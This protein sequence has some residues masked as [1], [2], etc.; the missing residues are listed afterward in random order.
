M[1]I[2][3]AAIKGVPEELIEAARID[4]ASEIQVFRRIIVP[5]I[6]GSLITVA[7]TIF[8]VILKVFDIVF[9]TTGGRFGSDVIANRM[10]QELVRFRNPGLAS[11]LA[12][13]LLVAVVPVMVINVRNRRQGVGRDGRSRKPQPKARRR[14][15]SFLGVGC[16][17]WGRPLV[18]AAPPSSSP[19]WVA[20]HRGPVDVLSAPPTTS[21]RPMVRRCC[22]LSRPPDLANYEQCHGQRMFDACQH[23]RRRPG[24]CHPYHPGRLPPTPS[25]D[26]VPRTQLRRGGGPH[27]PLQMGLVPLLQVYNRNGPDRDLPR[28]LVGPHRFGLPSLSHPL[29]YIS[30]RSGPA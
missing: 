2:L 5:T 11:A 7:T 3:S 9:V 22:T 18:A 14:E 4:G 1:V 15:P 26:A 13:V 21:T 27:R 8:I 6:R 29:Q 24:D 16:A 17:R 28:H 19:S 12:V 10:F 20:P 23:S 30:L 25:P